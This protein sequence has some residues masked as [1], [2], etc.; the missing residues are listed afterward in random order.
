MSPAETRT[1]RIAVANWALQ[2]GYADVAAWML[3]QDKHEHETKRAAKSKTRKAPPSATVTAWNGK[4]F[5][6]SKHLIET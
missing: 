4:K 6:I 1:R 3:A 2:N 5:K